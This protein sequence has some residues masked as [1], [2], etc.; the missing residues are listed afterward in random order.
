MSE[1]NTDEWKLRPFGNSVDNE[2]SYAGALVIMDFYDLE[3]NLGFIYIKLKMC[4]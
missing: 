2:L 3:T 1:K 4:R